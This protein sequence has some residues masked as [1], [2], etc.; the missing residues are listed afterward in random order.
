VFD[1]FLG[2]DLGQ[3]NDHTAVVL[4]EEQL[5]V[6]ERAAPHINVP[7]EGWHSPADLTLW[8]AEETR[9][10]TGTFGRPGDPI[11]AIRHLARL[12]LGTSY[13][14]VVEYVRR[15][16]TTPPLTPERTAIIVDQT[17]VGRAVVDFM[18]EAGL[19]VIPVTITGGATVTGNTT[20]GFH[21]SKRELVACTQVALQNRLLKIAAELP[22]A[23]TLTSELAGM[24]V[25]VTTAANE[26][27]GEWR[28][29]KNDD[30]ALAA[31]LS[32]WFRGWYSENL[33]R[34]ARNAR[35]YY[36][37]PPAPPLTERQR[38]VRAGTY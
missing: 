24:K 19:P 2:V 6:S 35:A 27:Y 34:Q 16:Y 25:K 15:L 32:V 26:V 37:N 3:V 5:W 8:Q 1:F 21:V 10:W 13:P 12:D 18:W 11:L 23:G 30:L 28:S 17:G 14:S 22:H 20:E 29:G 4:A 31:C 36:E 9:R 38:L 7:A 33:D